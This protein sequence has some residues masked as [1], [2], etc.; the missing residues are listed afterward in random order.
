[1]P[2][3]NVYFSMLIGK[4]KYIYKEYIFLLFLSLFILRE[5]EH[6]QVG[7]GQKERERESQVCAEPDVGLELTNRE[8][9]T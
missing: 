9:M 4:L 8:I 7:E 3:I 6:A 5:T 2:L 1:M